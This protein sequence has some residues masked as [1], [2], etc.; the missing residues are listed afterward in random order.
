M[1]SRE[2]YVTHSEALDL[3]AKEIGVSVQI[4]K[5]RQIEAEEE[6]RRAREH[7]LARAEAARHAAA[8]AARKKV[9]GEFLKA[10]RIRAWVGTEE[11]L[12]EVRSEDDFVCPKCGGRPQVVQDLIG[13]LAN[14]HAPRRRWSDRCLGPAKHFHASPAFNIKTACACGEVVTFACVCLPARDLV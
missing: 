11:N 9:F 1:S 10:G 8:E 7:A 4:L 14:A 5:E 3:L 12:P 13:M 6:E 2:I